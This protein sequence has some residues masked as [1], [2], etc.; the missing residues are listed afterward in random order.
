MKSLKF[1]LPILLVLIIQSCKDSSNP[2]FQI[3]ENFV[4]P[5]KIGNKWNYHDSSIFTNPRP[6]SIQGL[7]NDYFYDVEVSVTKDTVLNSIL[8][9][10]M[11]EKMVGMIETSESYGYYA[12]TQDGLIKYAYTSGGYLGLPKTNKSIQLLFKGSYYSSITELI[13]A[14]EIKTANLKSLYDSLYYFQPPRVIYKYPIVENTEWV[15]SGNDIL[16]N[17]Q[18]V[19]KTIL[20]TNLGNMECY[21]IKWKYDFDNDGNWDEDFVVYEYVNSKGKLKV[22]YT[23]KDMVITSIEHPDGIGLVDVTFEQIITAINF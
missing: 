3:N 14:I 13:K 16:I 23:F 1:L 2:G 4:Y 11:F 5:L 19:G 8:V 15:F 21:K 10:E 12:N 9:K 18:Y 22:T 20:Q 17:K 7:L 6:D